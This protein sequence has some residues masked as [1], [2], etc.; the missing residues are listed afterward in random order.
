MGMTVVILV[1]SQVGMWGPTDSGPIPTHYFLSG[2]TA[3]DFEVSY[4][5]RGMNMKQT[6][7]PV[8][9]DDV[10]LVFSIVFSPVFGGIL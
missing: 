8:A 9:W 10:C 7:F 6:K 2:G 1:R 4:H 5:L 3:P